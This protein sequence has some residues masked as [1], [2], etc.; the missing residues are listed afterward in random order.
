MSFETIIRKIMEEDPQMIEL[1]KDKMLKYINHR[2]FPT[3]YF[4]MYQQQL[5]CLI[6][7]ERVFLRALVLVF[8]SLNME[9]ISALQGENMID[10]NQRKILIQKFNRVEP[11][12]IK[13]FNE[14]IEDIKINYLF[15]LCEE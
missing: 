3:I 6:S 12:F 11:S 4:R 14:E 5:V 10:R 2:L 8:N 1:V 13:Q 9:R 15:N 7:F